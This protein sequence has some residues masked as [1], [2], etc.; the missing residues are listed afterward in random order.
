MEEHHLRMQAQYLQEMAEVKAAEE[1]ERRQE[2]EAELE[3]LRAQLV[4]L[5][6]KSE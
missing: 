4:N 6:N 2:L 1:V 5:E 3:R